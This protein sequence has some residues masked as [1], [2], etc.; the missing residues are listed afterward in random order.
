VLLDPLDEAVHR[1]SAPIYQKVLSQ[2]AD[3][4]SRLQGRSA[5]LI[6]SGYHAQV[7][8]A[9]D[10]TLLFAEREGNRLPLHSSGAAN[11]R[12]SIGLDHSASL[13]ELKSEISTQPLNF[14]A[15]AL[16]RPVVQDTLLPTI[17]YVAGPSELAYLG[18]SQVLYSVLGRSMPAVLPRCGFTLVDRRI[19]RWMEK[20]QVG[21][22]DV[23]Q[24]KEHV[25]QRIASSA[26]AEGW[27]ERFDQAKRD[28]VVLLARLRTDIEALDPTLLDT[29]NHTEEKILYQVERLK[30][31]LTRSA[32]KRSEVLE[33]HEQ[34]LLGAL[35]PEKELQ[36]RM[37]SGAWFLGRAGYGL[38]ERLLEQIP[39]DSSGHYIMSL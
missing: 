23:W 9:E 28:L 24:G 3:L 25:T 15:N 37:V 20:Y 5:E 6:K 22:G 26:F 27:S 35:M 11:Q 31:K 39:A 1:L 34:A 16:L 36:E 2:T 7:H 32:L 18:Q 4:R 21:V 38:L 8:I 33:R 12:L 19:E 29:L 17:A 10:S 14:S 30:G 13:E